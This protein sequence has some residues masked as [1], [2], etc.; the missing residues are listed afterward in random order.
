MFGE[1]GYDGGLTV[2]PGCGNECAV[3]VRDRRDFEHC[4]LGMLG[5]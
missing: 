2:M 1:I 3:E 5:D 4:V